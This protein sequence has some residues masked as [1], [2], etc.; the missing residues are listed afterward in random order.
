MPETLV[1]VEGDDAGGLLLGGEPVDVDFHGTVYAVSLAVRDEQVLVVE[2]EHA[3]SCDVWRGEFAASYVEDITAK[4]GSLKRFAVFVRMLAG[5]VAGG[6]RSVALDLL[7]VDDLALLKARKAAGRGDGA[8]GTAPRAGGAASA[9]SAGL[10]RGAAHKRYLILTYASEYERVHFPLPLAEAPPTPKRLKARLREARH[11]LA[12]AAAATAAAAQQQ[13][14]Q[15][16]LQQQAG[17][18]GRGGEAL[19]GCDAELLA[20]RLEVMAAS[21]ERERSEHRRELRRKARELQELQAE[22]CACRDGA[23]ELRQR[24]KALE[25]QLA[26]AAPQQQALRRGGGGGGAPAGPAPKR[27]AWGGGG[28]GIGSAGSEAARGW[29]ASSYLSGAGKFPGGASSKYPPRRAAPAQQGAPSS[30]GTS[31]ASSRGASPYNKPWAQNSTPPRPPRP[32][33]APAR[34]RFDPTEYVRQRR[35]QQEAAAQRRGPGSRGSSP[36]RSVGPSGGSTPRGLA[37]P[38]APRRGPGGATPSRQGSLERSGSAGAAR[39]GGAAGGDGS[40]RALR[41]STD[42][43]AGGR[44]GGSARRE[45]LGAAYGTT[46]TAGSTGGSRSSSRGR[47]PPGGLVRGH[48]PAGR[49]GSRAAS[50]GAALA[51]VREQLTSFMAKQQLAQQLE[52]PGAWTGDGRGCAGG[53]IADID[54]RLAALQAFLRQAKSS[55]RAT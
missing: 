28:S 44:S 52:H 16:Q 1:L 19:D 51:G 40:I 22:L 37:S 8:A 14:Q 25:Q 24:V 3:E 18:G 50:P 17:A 20:C 27:G 5:A 21:L 47:Q 6:R 23:R 12:H 13:Q 35:A 9:A 53:E 34:Q 49:E 30:R 7:T 48:S 29:Q 26:A 2:V 38:A 36:A 43:G 11:Q 31:P 54:A 45:R 10:P 42:S 39:R 4:A 55:V 46:G 32:S 33:S 15:Q 41:G